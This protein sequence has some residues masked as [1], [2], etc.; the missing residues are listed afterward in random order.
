VAAALLLAG[1]ANLPIGLPSP[2]SAQITPADAA[3]AWQQ[4]DAMDKNAPSDQ[5]K[6]PEEARTGTIDY[7]GKQEEALR[8]FLSTY[9]DDAHAPE[10]KLRLAHL[11]ATRADIEQDPAERRASDA[12]L[13]ELEGEPAMKDCRA[14]I[15]FARISIF[16]QRVDAL[17]GDNR[18]ALLEKARSY[19]KEFPDDRRVA[20]LLAEVASA[21]EDEPKTART[22]LDQ[23]L[24]KAKT[25]ELKARI[26]D[27]LKRLALLG[28]PLEMKWL[29]TDGTKIDMQNLQGKVVL[30][31]F[32]ASWSAPSMQELD[33]VRGLAAS[34]PPDSLQTLGICL[35]N[36]PVSVPDMLSDHGIGW[37][38]YCDGQGW[39]GQLVRSLGINELPELWV[40]DR[41]G[42]LR[43]LDAKDD[44]A[45][46]IRKVARD[47]GQ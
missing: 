30:I 42:V 18:D 23:A 14:D 7:L 5:W 24:P 4:I 6:T 1:T 3:G 2:V 41:D 22:L 16:M 46:L 35:D 28:K 33:W 38:V 25:P 26:G 43:A 45:E 11:L 8:G 31:Y 19:A 12:L 10:A 17:T 47:S 34:F 40:V 20:P 29:A 13:D 44:A 15:E 9:P 32:F 37:P 36:D 39:Q 21:Y 27:D